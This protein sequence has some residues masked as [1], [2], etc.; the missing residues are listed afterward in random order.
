MFFGSGEMSL[1]SQFSMKK[2]R[3]SHKKHRRHSRKKNNKTMAQSINKMLESEMNLWKDTFEP[4]KDKMVDSFEPLKDNMIDRFE[5]F[6]DNMIDRFEPFKDKVTDTFEPFKEKVTNSKVFAPCLGR[7]F[8][9]NEGFDENTIM[10]P[11]W[12]HGSMVPSAKAS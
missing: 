6:K 4:F 10:E 12:C 2:Y 5:P 8:T 9:V 7:S 3:N 11:P 1:L